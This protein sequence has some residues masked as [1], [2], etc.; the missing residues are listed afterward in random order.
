MQRLPARYKS[1]LFFVLMAAVLAFESRI[2]FAHSPHDIVEALAISPNYDQDKIVFV[3]DPT[4]D[5]LK[6]TDGGFSWE[7]VVNGLDLLGPIT[8]IV[9]SPDFQY[10]QTL[11]ISVKGD[12]VYRSQNEGGSWIKVNEGLD[13]LRIDLLAISANYAADKIVLAAGSQGELYK[14][15]NEGD[16]WQL[17]LNAHTQIT[18]I[19]FFTDH[20]K[21]SILIG[22]Q[23]GNLYLSIDRGRNWQQKYRFSGAGAITS[24][25]ISP[26]VADDGAIFIGTEDK[27]VF[28]SA[29]R[30]TSFVAVNNGISNY[31]KT[32]FGHKEVPKSIRSLVISPN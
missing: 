26:Q 21:N 1:F 13:N 29:D 3:A 14:T 20:E 10:D 24:I 15:D 2:V 32:I 9:I 4:N 8:S 12:G 18:A 22:D 30:G 23:Q 19:A 31:K 5:L 16:S 27:G 6:S 11:F 7:Q 17:V 25:A 28:K